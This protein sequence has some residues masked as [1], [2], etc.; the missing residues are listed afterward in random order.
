MKKKIDEI[1]YLLSANVESNIGLLTGLG[2]Q[3]LTCSELFLQNKISQEWLT[4]LHNV[5]EQKIENED[6]MATKMQNG[7]IKSLR[8]IILN[9]WYRLSL[10]QNK[11][12]FLQSWFFWCCKCFKKKKILKPTMP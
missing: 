6:F 12:C 2:G 8:W 5:L 3:I 1:T 4:H 9:I 10:L 7:F 11:G